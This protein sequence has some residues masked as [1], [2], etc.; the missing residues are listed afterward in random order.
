MVGEGEVLAMRLRIGSGFGIPVFVHWTFAF[1]PL[2]ILLRPNDANEDQ[3]LAMLIALPFIFACV[4][5][6]EF[7]HALTARRFGID[8]LDVTLYPIGGVAR[9]MRMTEKPLEEFLIAVAGPAVNVVLVVLLACLL[10]PLAILDPLQVAGSLAFHVASIVAI[11]NVVMIAFNLLPIFPMDGG[12]VLRAL[13]TAL[14]G[15]FQAT[16][17]AVGIGMAMAVLIGLAGMFLL[18]GAIMLPVV[19]AFV[20]VAGMQELASVR[21]RQRRQ[22]WED[23]E[24]LEVLPVRPVKP[25]VSL[26]PPPLPALMFQPKI[27]VYT[28]DNQTGTWRKDSP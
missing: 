2:L 18:R 8:T 3:L 14:V 21:A 26:S 17:I 24:P 11:A 27:S 7:G 20:F 9:L 19:M 16:Q 10:I 13:L 1:L 28:W 15:H 5:F 12:R 4:V 25:L 23:D 22:A 6:H